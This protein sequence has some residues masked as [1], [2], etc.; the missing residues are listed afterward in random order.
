ML[1]ETALPISFSFY[2]MQYERL[3]EIWRN[4]NMDD[5]DKR[6]IVNLYENNY[7]RFW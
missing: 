2:G 7:P 4:A 5:K 3:V 1:T 6:V